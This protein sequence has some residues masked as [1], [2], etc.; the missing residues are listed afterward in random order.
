MTYSFTINIDVMKIL[1]F[2][3]IGCIVAYFIVLFFEI[4]NL[5]SYLKKNNYSLLP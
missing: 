1:K 5:K 3:L 2:Y 4:D